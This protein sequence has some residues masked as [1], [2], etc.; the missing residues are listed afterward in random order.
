MVGFSFA[1]PGY[2]ACNG[3][4]LQISQNPVLFSLLSTT[5]GGDGLNTFA[6]PDFRGR[7]P[8]NRGQG[9]GLSNYAIGQAGGLEEI[10][11][12]TQQ[13]PPHNHATTG[14]FTGTM[15]C[16]SGPGNQLGPAGNAAAAGAAF[17]DDPLSADAST[18]KAVHIT[19]LRSRIDLARAALLLGPYPYADAI[20]TGTTLINAQHIVDLRT[21]LAQAYAANGAMPP[22]YTD[23][24]L[25]SGMPIRAAHITELRAAVVGLTPVASYSNAA[26]D[27]DMAAGTV[28]LA[29][30]IAPTT[31]LTGGSQP[32]NNLQPYLCV[33]FLIAIEGI[34]PND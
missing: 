26:P 27:A 25:T 19:E 21:A 1:P 31:G 33:A 30:N 20:V 10:T 2:A 9:T 22:A 13:V 12:T 5:Y 32:H 16:N 17:S 29:G 3:Q 6:L 8:I 28:A 11:L 4:L 7:L 24:V 34:D 23:P 18:I 15:K 14:Q